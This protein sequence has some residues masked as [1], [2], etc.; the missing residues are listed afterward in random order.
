MQLR[1]L[2]LFLAFAAFGWGICVVGVFVSWPEAMNLLQGLGAKPMPYD[3]MLDYWLR[4]VCGA[5]SLV[6]L[7]YI[8]MMIWPLKFFT[9]IPWFGALM[10]VEGTILL[11]HGLRLSLPPFPFYGD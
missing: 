10:I 7:W 9:A 1:L 4:M 3:P 8:I 5:F 11:V 6:G 2:R